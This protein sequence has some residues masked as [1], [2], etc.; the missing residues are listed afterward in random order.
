ML[1]FTDLN[2][3][4][5]MQPLMLHCFCALRRKIRQDKDDIL[6]KTEVRSLNLIVA[7]GGDGGSVLF[8][9]ISGIFIAVFYMYCSLNLTQVT[10][11]LF[12]LMQEYRHQLPAELQAK[13][14]FF[15]RDPLDKQVDFF[16]GGVMW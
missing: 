13:K 11:N 16:F 7:L 4:T 14:Y 2:M 9:Q 6:S 15:L 12:F 1:G 8:Q 10:P 3:L 5:M